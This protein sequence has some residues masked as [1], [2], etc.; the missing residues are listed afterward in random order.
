MLDMLDKNVFICKAKIS[1]LH[2]KMRTDEKEQTDYFELQQ[3]T[4][5]LSR[6]REP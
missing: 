3:Q 2:L 4:C 6:L 5:F 1:N